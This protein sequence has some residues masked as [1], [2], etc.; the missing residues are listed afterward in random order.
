MNL[1]IVHPI[2]RVH[3]L[4]IERSDA[5]PWRLPLGSGSDSDRRYA[6]ASHVPTGNPEGSRLSVAEALDT[7]LPWLPNTARRGD[8][9]NRSKRLSTMAASTRLGPVLDLHRKREAV[10]QFETPNFASV[11]G[12]YMFKELSD[13]ALKIELVWR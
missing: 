10:P 6:R 9:Q 12:A 2:S 1:E 5:R 4:G 13:L 11:H 8:E 3:G 7:G